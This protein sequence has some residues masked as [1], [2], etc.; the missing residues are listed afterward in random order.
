MKKIFVALVLALGFGSAMDA[1]TVISN[2]KMTHDGTN[3]TVSFDLDTD[4]KGLP[5][6]RKEVIT[7]YIYN[8]KDTLFFDRVE[9]YG[10][11][12]FKR[13]RQINAI[14]GD[15]DWELGENQTLKGTVY[16]YTAQVPLKR[17]MKSANLGIKR[18]LVGCAC[19]KDGADENLAEGVA[20][21]EVYLLSP[22][23]LSSQTYSFN[24]FLSKIAA[25]SLKK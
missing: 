9:V 22:S 16:Q 15:K 23:L 8:E 3:V 1:Q 19:E 14:N 6:R 13:E 7:P 11:G 18:Q 2:E 24:T 5:S 17:W 10:K 25:T 4:V 12:R 21:F 20:L